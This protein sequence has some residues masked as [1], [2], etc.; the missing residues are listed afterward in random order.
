MSG[1]RFDCQDNICADRAQYQL[2]YGCIWR[3]DCDLYHDKKADEAVKKDDTYYFY[4][5]Q[6]TVGYD[7]KPL[8][9]NIEIKLKKGQILTIIGPNASGKTT[10]LKTITK[11]LKKH[12]RNG[13]YQ[14]SRD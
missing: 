8:I 10:I 14:P 3:T 9:E 4:T 13:I 6:L 1:M 5:E 2:G 7:G 11:F 12:N